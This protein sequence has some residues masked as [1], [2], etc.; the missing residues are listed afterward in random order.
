MTEPPERPHTDWKEVRAGAKRG[1]RR[2]FRMIR[3]TEKSEEYDA[4]RESILVSFGKLFS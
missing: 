2:G 4:G 1:A 3:N